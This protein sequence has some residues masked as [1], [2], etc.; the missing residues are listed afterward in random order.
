MI[1]RRAGKSIRLSRLPE[2]NQKKLDLAEVTPGA[3]A[4]FRHVAQ[5][6]KAH[7]ARLDVLFHAYLLYRRLSG[8]DRLANSYKAGTSANRWPQDT[9]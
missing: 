9:P 4:E 8:W 7:Q 3:A 5:Q 1:L 2:L 6:P